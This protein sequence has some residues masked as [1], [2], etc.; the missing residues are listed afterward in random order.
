M[1][2]LG[3][4]L[5]ILLAALAALMLAPRAALLI[6]VLLAGA[7]FAAS[8]LL[9]GLAHLW[10]AP[11]SAIV[12]CLLF[13]PLWS[14]RRQEAVLRFLAQEAARLEAEPGLLGAS[15]PRGPAGRSLDHR[16]EAVYCMSS[17]LRDLRQFLSDALESLPEATVICTPEGRVLLANRRCA[18]LCA[19]AVGVAQAK[20]RRACRPT[21]TSC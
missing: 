13:Y 3:T 2:W 20:G 7:A 6:S 8:L 16:M 19:A 10:F 1:F 11:A 9:M 14:W 4:L 5:P 15:P 12:G 17:R 18:M 21:C